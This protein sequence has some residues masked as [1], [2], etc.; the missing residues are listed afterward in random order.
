MEALKYPE[1]KATHPNTVQEDG[2]SPNDFNTSH[3]TG[4]AFPSMQ[5]YTVSCG[6]QTF[7]IFTPLAR[8]TLL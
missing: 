4:K 7:N 2:F 3:P 1:G 8:S 6:Q 5:T